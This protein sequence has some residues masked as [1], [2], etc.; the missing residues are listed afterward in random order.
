MVLSL[1][2]PQRALP[3]SRWILWFVAP[4]SVVVFVTEVCRA[5]KGSRR[6]RPAALL[7]LHMFCAAGQ[8]DHS[9]EELFHPRSL[10]PAQELRSYIRL[11]D[12]TSA[13]DRNENKNAILG[14]RSAGRGLNGSHTTKNQ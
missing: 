10:G 6:D 2:S 11:N 14:S 1:I 7:R 5:W 13:E 4:A 9:G 8:Q 12:M 3:S